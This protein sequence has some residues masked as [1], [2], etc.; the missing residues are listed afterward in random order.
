MQKPCIAKSQHISAVFNISA[1]FSSEKRMRM[2]LCGD[3]WHNWQQTEAPNCRKFRHSTG[4]WPT[5]H[6]NTIRKLQCAQLANSLPAAN[7]VNKNSLKI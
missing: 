2:I 6:K 5:T 3:V 4:N 7:G 1:H